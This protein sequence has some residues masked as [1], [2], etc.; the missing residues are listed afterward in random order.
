MNLSHSTFVPGGVASHG[1]LPLDSPY[2]FVIGLA[3]AILLLLLTLLIRE[4]CV[5]QRFQCRCDG[6]GYASFDDFGASCAEACDCCQRT[7]IDSCLYACCPKRGVSLS[8]RV[9]SARRPSS[10]FFQSLDAADLLT[11]AICCSVSLIRSLI[12]KCSST[13][14]VELNTFAGRHNNRCIMFRLFTSTRW[15]R[16]SS[17]NI[18]TKALLLLRLSLFQRSPSAR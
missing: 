14:F 3:G 2:L 5:G 7:S 16:F 17:S 10:L 8:G 9:D 1:Q 4:L 6:P 11:C 15:K 12:D 18:L 13:L